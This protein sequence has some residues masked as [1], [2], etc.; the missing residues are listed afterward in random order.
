MNGKQQVCSMTSSGFISLTT[1]ESPPFF[2]SS[3][4][5]LLTSDI[6]FPFSLFSLY[7]STSLMRFLWTLLG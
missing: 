2:A 4:S 5:L 6:F 1:S 3:S 7:L